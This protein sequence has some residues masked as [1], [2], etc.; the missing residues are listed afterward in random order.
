ME[1]LNLIDLLKNGTAL[2]VYTKGAIPGDAI[3]E[4]HTEGGP[5]EQKVR[6]SV[7]I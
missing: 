3:Q 4:Y 1:K 5:L 7:R 2:I 6:C